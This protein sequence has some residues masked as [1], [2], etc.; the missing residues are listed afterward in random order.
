M[1]NKMDLTVI[2][3]TANLISDYFAD[4]V[5]KKLLEVLGD[6]P[7]ISVSQKPID[8]GENICVGEIGA[9]NYNVYFQI[10]KGAKA[11]KTRYVMMAEDDTLYPPEHFLQRPPVGSFAYN[12]NRWTVRH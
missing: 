10:L 11:A 8:F 6:T 7:L 2:Y 5:R 9:S 3:Y 4:N 12:L 1:V